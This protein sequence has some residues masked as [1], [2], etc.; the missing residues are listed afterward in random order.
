MRSC[1]GTT[2]PVT[3]IVIAKAGT[4]PQ[5]QKTIAGFKITSKINRMDFDISASIPCV[6]LGEDVEIFANAE[7]KKTKDVKKVIMYLQCSRLKI[8]NTN[9]KSNIK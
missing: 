3:L 4:N 1:H 6:V 5:N 8:M 9:H 2:K 7:F